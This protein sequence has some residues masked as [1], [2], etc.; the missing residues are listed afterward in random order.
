MVLTNNL[1]L[2]DITELDLLALSEKHL[3]PS[4]FIVVKTYINLKNKHKQDYRYSDKLKQL[5]LNIYI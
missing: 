1:Q 2:N 5:A 4:S 3:S